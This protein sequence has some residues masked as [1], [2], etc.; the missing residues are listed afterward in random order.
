[1]K[2]MQSIIQSIIPL[3]KPY[4]EQAE[5]DAVNSI[6]Y[7]RRIAIGDV[8][9]EFE[10]AFAKKI[11]RKYCVV[12]NSGTVALY[13]ALKALGL[14]GSVIMPALTCNVVLYAVLNAGLRPIFAD[15]ERE[16]HNIDLST[17]SRDQ[18][19]NANGVIM[20]HAYGHSANIENIEDYAEKY[21]LKIIED[22][23]QATGG[24]YNTKYLGGFGDISIASFYGPKNMTAGH[25]GAILTDDDEIYYRCLCARGPIPYKFYEDII[26]MNFRMT[27]IQAAMAM[28]QLNKLDKMIE[29]RRM[30]A[31]KYNNELQN[32]DI[33]LPVEKN[34]AKHS[35]YKYHIVLPKYIN[36]NEFISEMD[37]MGIQVGI[38]NDPP[39]HKSSY[40][41]YMFNENINLP[42][43]E[44]L[45]PR[46]VSL[47]MFPELTD[48]EIYIVCTG[49]EDVNSKL[50]NKS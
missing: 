7:N 35:Y 44:D 29:M 10:E 43:T 24:S 1:M 17:L 48:E 31:K 11:G 12:V 5:I 6:L 13:L 15:V 49:I 36:K 33:V 3:G 30:I 25:G 27:D 22:F 38:L 42:I 14:K 18:L 37:K 40:F 46:T 34:Y 21:N 28:V 8:V 47:P 2:S 19:E 16:T 41:K 20:I 45:A 23:A 32:L 50:Q 39:I 4:I 9:H 26:P